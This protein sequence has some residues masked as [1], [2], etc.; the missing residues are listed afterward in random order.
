M[1]RGAA[2]VLCGAIFGLVV[3]VAATER[4]ARDTLDPTWMWLHTG[5][6]TGVF[7]G[8]VFYCGFAA[9]H[10]TQHIPCPLQRSTW[11]LVT[12]PGNAL[13]SCFYYCTI[14]QQYR[15]EG[16]GKLLTRA[17]LEANKKAGQNDPS[18]PGSPGSD[19]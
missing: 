12:I 17:S 8:L 9:L 2:I 13:G 18:D 19:R 6:K 1:S 5:A 16:K 14:Y 11:L 15:K 7:L 3:I 10:S 4:L